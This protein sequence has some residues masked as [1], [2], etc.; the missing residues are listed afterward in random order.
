MMSTMVPYLNEHVYERI[1][2]D[3]ILAA[4]VF[5]AVEFLQT[6]TCRRRVDGDIVLAGRKMSE[7]M[8]L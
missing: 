1:Q 2:W 6:R 3:Q 8:V 4:V 7:C 5:S